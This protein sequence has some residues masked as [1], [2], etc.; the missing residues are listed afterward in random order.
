MDSKDFQLPLY[1][2]EKYVHGEFG[3]Y[4]TN[5]SVYVAAQIDHFDLQ[6]RG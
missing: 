1:S 2:S 6:T 5:A 4:A 3:V